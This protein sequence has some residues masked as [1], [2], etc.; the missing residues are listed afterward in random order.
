MLTNSSQPLVDL[1]TLHG[2]RYTIDK[3]KPVLAQYID[4]R[5]NKVSQ[6]LAEEISKL[7]EGRQTNLVPLKDGREARLMLINTPQGLLINPLTVKARLNLREQ[8]MGYT[9]TENDKAAL[10]RHGHL[11][12]QVIVKPDDSK[13]PFRA[14]IGLDIENEKLMVL[15]VDKLILPDKILGVVLTPADKEQL[16]MGYPIKKDNLINLT[17]KRGARFTGFIRINPVNGKFKYDLIKASPAQS[18]TSLSSL[19]PE[20]G[21]SHLSPL[22]PVVEAV[23]ETPLLDRLQ[24]PYGKPSANGCTKFPQWYVSQ[25]DNS[26]R[27][28]RPGYQGEPAGRKSC[29]P[30]ASGIQSAS[31]AEPRAGRTRRPAGAGSGPGHRSEQTAVARLQRITAL[32]D[33]SA[34]DPRRRTCIQ[35]Q[36]AGDTTD[37]Q[38]GAYPS[39]KRRSR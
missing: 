24:L 11:G 30:N 33:K 18:V 22:Q 15:N 4:I 8:V 28:R 19:Q 39:Q 20:E 9:L 32:P 34:A 6:T 5:E 29:P 10:E 13:K 17:D 26:K 37:E 7:L 2:S 16:L 31:A 27:R 1:D 21:G 25:A 3:L 12:K 23:V 36:P 38:Q 14:L 35:T